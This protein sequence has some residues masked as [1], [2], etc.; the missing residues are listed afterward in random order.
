MGTN[1][2]VVK[3]KEEERE[4]LNEVLGSHGWLTLVHVLDQLVRRRG[5][6]VLTI[7]DDPER[8]LKAKSEYDG[9][10]SLVSDVKRLK[11]ILRL[12]PEE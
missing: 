5:E 6:D 12:N 10:R 11:E 7:N 2:P 4:S 9:A 1:R 8:L 3:L